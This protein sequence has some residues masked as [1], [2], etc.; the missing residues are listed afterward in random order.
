MDF[1]SPQL[2]PNSD[3]VWINATLPLLQSALALQDSSLTDTPQLRPLIVSSFDCDT[4]KVPQGHPESET[5]LVVIRNYLHA[6]LDSG[7]NAVD[8]EY[9]RAITPNLLP[10]LVHSRKFLKSLS[11][12]LL[13]AQS[14]NNEPV[15]IDA[16]G[17]VVTGDTYVSEGTTYAISAT[18][19][20]LRVAVNAVLRG[21][22]LTAAVL[23]RPPGHHCSHL[24]RINEAQMGFCVLNTAMQ[25]NCIIIVII[26]RYWRD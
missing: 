8:W 15:L 21:E 11:D 13:L 5:R 3:R 23:T 25:V 17:R 16:A 12:V 19:T 9:V 20:A 6:N 24:T 4:H 18:S 26:C 1:R 22:R 2:I 14:H 7:I 10:C